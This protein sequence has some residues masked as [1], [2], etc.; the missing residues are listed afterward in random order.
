MEGS[1][2]A[3]GLTH[4]RDRGWARGWRRPAPKPAASPARTHCPRSLSRPFFSSLR[5][6]KKPNNK[7]QK[8]GEGIN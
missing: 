4:D 2:R 5:G 3:R 8:S 1:E 7:N 6:K